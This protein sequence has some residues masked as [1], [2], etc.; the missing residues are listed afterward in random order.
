MRINEIKEKIKEMYKPLFSF[1]TSK[2]LDSLSTYFA[3]KNSIGKEINPIMNNIFS[4]F[5]LE[6]GSVIGYALS[7]FELIVFYYFSKGIEKGIKKII[8]KDVKIWKDIYLSFLYGSS[9]GYSYIAINNFSLFFSNQLPLEHSFF[10]FLIPFIF[11]GKNIFRKIKD[12][13]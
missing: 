6:V 11:Y 8:K 10:L 1:L 7:S 5:G 12:T 4:S 2:S 13:L 3:L 9:L